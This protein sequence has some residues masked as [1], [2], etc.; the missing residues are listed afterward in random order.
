MAFGPANL[1]EPNPSASVTG[2]DVSHPF[3]RSRLPQTAAFVKANFEDDLVAPS[4][5]TTT[6]TG[7]FIYA[8]ML[9][10]AAPRPVACSVPVM[11]RLSE[12]RADI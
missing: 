5:A 10:A 9:V 8:R 1:H 7:N 3:E 4:S 2:I 11:L 6:T 12:S